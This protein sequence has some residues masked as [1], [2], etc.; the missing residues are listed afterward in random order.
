MA[1]KGNGDKRL[2]ELTVGTPKGPFTA[3]FEKT[4]KVSDVVAAAIAAKGLA[5]NAE[6]FEIFFGEVALAPTTRTLVSFG[7][8]D[9]DKLIVAAQGDGV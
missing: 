6:D 5:G 2:L 3:E 7:L 1:S 9:G 8:K 4:A